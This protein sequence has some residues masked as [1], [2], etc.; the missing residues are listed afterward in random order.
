MSDPNAQ[1]REIPFEVLANALGIDLRRF[2][3]DELNKQWVGPCPYH[4]PRINTGCFRYYD[5]GRFNCFV[6]LKGF[7]GRGAIDF[8]KLMRAAGVQQAVK[9]LQPYAHTVP[10]KQKP[11]SR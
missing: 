8:A 11:P 6:C 9:F 5:D 7:S 1:L 3:R 10:L 4:K 2:K